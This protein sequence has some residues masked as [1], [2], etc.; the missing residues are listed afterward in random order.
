MMPIPVINCYYIYYDF[1]WI[2][3]NFDLPKISCLSTKSSYCI[4]FY[5]PICISNMGQL[6]QNYKIPSQNRKALSSLQVARCIDALSI[7]DFRIRSEA[8]HKTLQLPTW[9]RYEICTIWKSC[10]IFSKLCWSN[11]PFICKGFQVSNMAST[12]DKF[13]IFFCQLPISLVTPFENPQRWMGQN[14]FPILLL[15]DDNMIEEE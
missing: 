9:V 2:S 11:L 5:L 6:C 13:S 3:Q 12:I 8:L 15:N 7:K 14:T 1:S 10:K 4:L